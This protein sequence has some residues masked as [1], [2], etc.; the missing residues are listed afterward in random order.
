[1]IRFFISA[2]TY[3]LSHKRLLICSLFLLTIGLIFSFRHLEYKEDIAEFLPDNE[4][5]EHINAIYQHIGNSN[6]LFVNFSLTSSTSLTSA[7]AQIIEA[8][9]DFTFRLQEKDSLH[10]IPEIITQVDESQFL[11]L[12]E[13]IQT[14][15]PYFLTES[16]YRRI[17]SLLLQDRFVA[18]QLREDKQLLM[19]P[20]GSMMK[21]NIVADPLHLFSPL[22][23]KLKD[24]Q[25]GNN[26]ELNNGYIFSTDGRKGRVII[27]S[28]YG[29]SE[30][31]GNTELLHLIEQTAK[32]VEQIFWD[33]KISCFG[34]PAI[35]VTN[36]NQIKND[37]ILAIILSVVL[38]LVLLIYFFRNGRNL[39]LIFFS[40]LF[41]WL[42]ALG[43]IAVFNDS[44]SV[45]AIGIS[46]IFIGIAINYPLHFIDHLKHQPNRKQALKEIIPPLLIGNITTVGAF[47]SLV[48]I[49][50][51]AMRDMGL[52]GSLLLA[53]TILFVLIYL[54]HFLRRGKNREV[55]AVKEVRNLQFGR[56]AT[57]APET[58]KWIV[59]PVV[60]LTFV[61]LYLSQ[62][63]SFEADMNKINYMTAQ[64][65]EDM[66]ELLQSIEKKDKE[67]VYFISEGR[68]MDEVLSVQERNKP[69]LDS[70]RQA[71]LIE[72]ISGIG[73]F[74]P[75]KKE[76]QNRIERWNNFWNVHKETLLQQIEQAGRDEGFKQGAFDAFSQLLSAYYTPQEEDYF[77]PITALAN[78]YLIK[79]ENKSMIINLLYC[80]KKHTAALEETLKR[81]A[82]KAFIFDSRNIGERMVDSL[83][84]D[85][86][87]VLYL[88][89]FIVF[90]FLSIS[91]GRLEL[92]LLSFIPL[93]VSWIWILGIMQLGDMRFNIVNVILATFIFGQGDDY[94]I[95][96]T[97]G[98]IYEY[99]YRRKMLASYK[100]SI[101]LS[102]LIMFIGIGTLIFA[103]HPAM[104][105]LAEVTIVGMFS[106]VMMAYI[107]P[108]LIFRWLT[109]NKNGF[110]EVPLTL[111][112]ILFSVYSFIAF[113]I[114]SLSIT[115]TG[116]ILFGF[117]KK[118]KKKKMCYHSMLCWVSRFVINHIPGV[119]FKY[120]NLSGETFDK[121]AIIISNHQS[122]LDLMCLMM[123]TPKLIILTNDWV[124]NNPFYGRLIKYADFYP[125]SNGIENSID[126]L[127]EAVKNGY[128][129]VVFPEGTRSE[130]CAIHRFHRGAFYLAE[131]LHIDILPVFIHGAGHVLPKKDFMLREG[132]ITMQTHSRITQNDTRFAID[133]HTRTKQVRKYYQETF[134]ALS[135][136][137][138]TAAYFKSFVLHNYLYKGTDIERAVRK[139]VK[140]SEKLNIIYTY[141]GNNTVLIINN[142]YGAFSFLF[143]LVH[144]Q[145]QVIA[146]ERDEEKVAIAN[147]CTGLPK[148]L[149]IYEEEKLPAMNFS[150]IYLLNPDEVQRK[151]YHNYNLQIIE[152]HG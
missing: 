10:T 27:T 7:Q 11:E 52:F 120:E 147:S 29:V 98:L 50:S 130:D 55:K 134:A 15:I 107:I 117:R 44:I 35:A 132:T 118:T 64:Q 36:A 102:A 92:S 93:A 91:F 9:D 148:N 131:I 73:V 77:T 133:Y 96:I 66:N 84:D 67:I 150:Q 42:F 146:I 79:N 65:R 109:R 74:L 124:W 3:F 75:S 78:N 110:R 86:N 43:L 17:D 48:F 21:Q 125:V 41:G 18:S 58:K 54:P 53:G 1:M 71:G 137:I 88:C 97:E 144:K 30:T 119:R 112:R 138:E 12:T 105:S 136:R 116:F 2:Y 39:F 82:D 33:V 143:A 101:I 142:G 31:T 8:I 129:I 59:I 69:L 99:A 37:S 104:R 34:A 152:T 106:V 83:S 6:K 25:A 56:M 89:G 49:N 57:F 24:F 90:I 122:H 145:V 140:K 111:K 123:L 19:L 100:N 14:N 126:R 40:V 141:Q 13:F 76:Q 62:F 32:E 38:I 87:Y 127:S 51:K 63:T 28:P 61:F 80:D 45:I 16:D 139:E 128:S 115:L 60:L 68:Q 72:S 81:E 70:L 94:T 23:L 46:S 4:S 20:S 47:L 149:T 95:F 113:L 121:P 114:G 26:E 5:N 85:F 22:L 103:K 135:Q 151:K 108:P